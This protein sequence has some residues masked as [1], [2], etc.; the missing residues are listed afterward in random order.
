MKKEKVRFCPEIN[1][2]AKKPLFFC[3]LT[4]YEPESKPAFLLHI[5]IKVLLYIMACEWAEV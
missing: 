1:T 2:I 3:I 4:P 5:C